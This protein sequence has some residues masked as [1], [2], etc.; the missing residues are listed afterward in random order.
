MRRPFE[1]TDEVMRKRIK[2]TLMEYISPLDP[3]W[4]DLDPDDSGYTCVADMLIESLMQI[5]HDARKAKP[6][7]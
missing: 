1:M 4:A 2:V 5:V 7:A 6:L 3:I